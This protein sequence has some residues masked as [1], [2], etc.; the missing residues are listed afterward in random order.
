MLFQILFSFIQIRDLIS[1]GFNVPLSNNTLTC[2]NLQ[3]IFDSNLTY[4][5]ENQ[6]IHSAPYDKLAGIVIYVKSSLNFINKSFSYD[7]INYAY[8]MTAVKIP[9]DTEL[10][11][12]EFLDMTIIKDFII[13][14]KSTYYNVIL[15]M[16]WNK[17][18]ASD[19]KYCQWN[20]FSILP[21]YNS[22]FKQFE[23]FGE[24][25]TW[26]KVCVNNRA[27]FHYVDDRPS[28]IINI[29]MKTTIIVASSIAGFIIFIIILLYLIARCQ[30][31]K[32]IREYNSEYSDSS[33]S[34]SSSY[35]DNINFNSEFFKELLGI[36]DS[37]GSL[38]KEGIG[39]LRSFQRM[40]ATKTFTI[41]F[42]KECY[43]MI[44]WVK[45]ILES[46]LAKIYI[47]QL[48][49]FELFYCYN[50]VFPTVIIT[51]I[52][53]FVVT[54]RFYYLL[55][56]NAI[57][58]ALGFGFG[59][60]N[61]SYKIAL[62]IIVPGFII[63]AIIFYLIFRG[64]IG[65]KFF[66][67]IH[68]ER[69]VFPFSF[70]VFNSLIIASILLLPFF[71]K[72]LY[73]VGSCLFICLILI[74]VVF[75]IEIIVGCI[76][77]FNKMSDY[78][79]FR[80]PLLASEILT[81]FYIPT[82]EHFVSIMTGDYKKN[83]NCIIGLISFGFL[84]PLFVIIITSQTIAVRKKYRNRKCIIYEVLDMFRQIAY[85]FVSA[86]DIPYACIGI[87][88]FWL[89]L[90]IFPHPYNDKSEYSLQIGNSLILII[91][92]I[93]VIAYDKLKMGLLSFYFSIIIIAV[94]CV[95][96]IMA[97]FLFFKYD[98]DIEEASEDSERKKAPSI[99]IAI[100]LTGYNPISWMFFGMII[101]VIVEYF[102]D[103]YSHYRTL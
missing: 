81:L 14:F 19:S 49:E 71:M 28:E 9:T 89:I 11:F 91:S 74:V 59:Y 47:R 93:I 26:E 36:G 61:Y 8:I 54:N 95:P 97:L 92:N 41:H 30:I 83:W 64:C 6:F 22:I 56:I 3:I 100:L 60:I 77:H 16:D 51:F 78:F 40:S 24:S 43:K 72:N 10:T 38:I 101:P 18:T 48:S 46:I 70:A 20:H 68:I 1:E 103:Y 45:N 63:G 85:A 17:Y 21:A 75:I 98:F 42:S 13:I 55:I 84:L 80:I 4:L 79:M 23:K 53:L 7:K 37:A 44:S 29:P 67:L 50:Y 73:S 66:E 32:K 52:T 86:F 82:V 12:T 90:T 25:S 87:E 76:H 94:A 62:C 99:I 39:L 31:R 35:F 88:C 58:T 33:L 2:D 34:S 5:C 65:R 69:F 57:F 102:N 15:T 27:C 96:A